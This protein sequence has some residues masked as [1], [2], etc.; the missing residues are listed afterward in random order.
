MNNILNVN[1]LNINIITIISIVI[2]VIILIYFYNKYTTVESFLDPY[3]CTMFEN[4]LYKHQRWNDIHQQREY[5]NYMAVPQHY[6][7]N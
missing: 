1:I 5:D 6:K 3:S 2:V 7:D 4:M